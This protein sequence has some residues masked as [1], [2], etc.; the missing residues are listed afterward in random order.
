MAAACLAAAPAAATSYNCSGDRLSLD[1]DV[2]PAAGRCAVDGMQASLRK[3]SDPVVC[4]LSN[5]QLRILTIDRSGRFTWE[6]TDSDRVVSG[7][8]E[9]L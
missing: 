7:T 8:C 6:D 1:V 4:H 5:P 9:R 3:P 2:D